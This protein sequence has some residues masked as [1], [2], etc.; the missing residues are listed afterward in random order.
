VLG[1]TWL[2]CGVEFVGLEVI[3]DV[4]RA[5]NNL[6]P[7]GPKPPEAVSSLEISHSSDLAVGTR[8]AND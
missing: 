1:A 6:L 5:A 2:K 8:P 4:S 7:Y 3:K